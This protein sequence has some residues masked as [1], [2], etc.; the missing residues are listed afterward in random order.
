MNRKLVARFLMIALSCVIATSTAQAKGPNTGT[1]ATQPSTSQPAATGGTTQPSTA[2]PAAPVLGPK[3]TA[4][5]VTL[6]AAT[7]KHATAQNTYSRALA[8]GFGTNGNDGTLV[9]AAKQ[10]TDA[11]SKARRDYL[12]F[13]TAASKAAKPTIEAE[14]E[15]VELAEKG[16]NAW[17]AA[18]LAKASSL[19]QK[20]QGTKDIEE[21][22]KALDAANAELN[23]A[24]AEFEE[25]KKQDEFDKLD[26]VTQATLRAQIFANSGLVPNSVA[27]AHKKPTS[28]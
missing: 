7:A 13:I 24:K 6:D 20:E 25:A 28:P 11:A 4:A 16:L 15:E 1:A 27:N 9:I 23:K 12:D 2:Q 19:K 26:P 3:A 22:K 5:K 18:T 21:A 8:L 14:V 10:A 17:K